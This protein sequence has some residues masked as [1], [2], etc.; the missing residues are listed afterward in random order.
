M[1]LAALQQAI[2]ERGLAFRGGFHP[3][4]D[5]PLVGGRFETLVLVGFTGRDQW[6]AFES[7]PEA[8]DGGPNPLD[9]WSERVIT[10]LADDL[11]ARA[12][13][14]FG[15]PPWAPF[16]RWAS[17]CEPVFPSPLGMLIHPDWGL[18]HSWR[19]ALAFSESI[20]IPSPDRRASLC[21][22][23]IEKPCLSACP[24]NAFTENGYDMAV[25]V[26]FLG[27]EEG[28]QCMNSGCKARRAC[29]V[30]ERH[31]YGG[32]QAAFHMRTFRGF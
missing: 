6:P 5:E 31:R 12:I 9:R 4:P 25:C 30:G 24:V 1:K 2:N 32:R 7:S 15:G 20:S 23:C 14:P 18:W 22:A 16:L 17:E 19:G 21:D 3:G 10:A 28:A 29:P 13:F 8:C 27:A 26:D 11:G